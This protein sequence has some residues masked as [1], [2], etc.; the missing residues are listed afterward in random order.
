MYPQLIQNLIDQFAR[1]PGIGPKTAERLVFY[2]LNQPPDRLHQFGEA[3]EHIKDNVKICQ[4]C[5]NFSDSD[6]C[7][8]CADSRRNQK[9]ICVVTKPQDLAMIEKAKMFDGRYHI[10]G[11]NINPADGIEPNDIR[12]SHLIERIRKDEVEEIILALN[13]DIPGETT[14]LYLAKLLRQFQNIKISRLGRGLPTGADL[15]YTDE[16]TMENAF[17]GRQ[18]LG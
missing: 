3:I 6:P 12:I 2:L 11:G 13:P 15:E 16:I 9:I 8:V 1:L 17:K 14:T 4:T 10:L 7:F 18:P 5:F